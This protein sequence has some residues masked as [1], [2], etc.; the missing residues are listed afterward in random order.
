MASKSRNINAYQDC[1]R[2]F[3]IASRDGHASRLCKTKGEAIHYRQRL[4]QFRSLLIDE[5]TEVYRMRPETFEKVGTTPFDLIKCRLVELKPA[6][7][8]QG[9][10]YPWSVELEKTELGPLLSGAGEVID[11]PVTNEEEL[12]G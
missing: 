5:L 8:I 1:R 6:S 9:V 4:Y 2:A 3:E 11:T 12:L 10:S 7:V